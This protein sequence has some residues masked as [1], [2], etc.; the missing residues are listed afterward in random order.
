MVFFVSLAHPQ[1]LQFSKLE[2]EK[3]LLKLVKMGLC[4][5]ETINKKKD[6]NNND[7]YANL[8]KKYNMI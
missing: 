5:I 3:E 4:G 6:I 8:A 7:F 1:T 2:F